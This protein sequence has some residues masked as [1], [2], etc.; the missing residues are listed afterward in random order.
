MLRL[1]RGRTANGDTTPLARLVAI[2]VVVGMLAVA[3]P[4]VFVLL[5][6]VLR[7]L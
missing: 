5:G 6:S 2:I 7:L 1:L 4:T 3:A